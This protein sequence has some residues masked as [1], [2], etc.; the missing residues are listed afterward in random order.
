MAV[1]GPAAGLAIGFFVVGA[2]IGVLIIF[3]VNKVRGSSTPTTMTLSF[4]PKT[5]ENDSS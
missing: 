3:V 1:L 4:T 2:L 5:F